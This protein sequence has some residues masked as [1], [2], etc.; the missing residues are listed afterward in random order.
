MAK[1]EIIT[2]LDIGSSQVVAVVARN[3][4]PTPRPPKSSARPVS[5]APD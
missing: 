4:I 5:R 1:P 3:T 2:G